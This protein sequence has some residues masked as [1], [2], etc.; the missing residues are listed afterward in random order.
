M[1]DKPI[2][3]P[4]D[5]DN[6]NPNK[7]QMHDRATW[8]YVVAMHKIMVQAGPYTFLR[9]AHYDQSAKTMPGATERRIR[10]Y[11]LLRAK[12]RAEAYF[13]NQNINAA[14]RSRSD[15]AAE[16]LCLTVDQERAR[17]LEVEASRVSDAESASGQ[18]LFIDNSDDVVD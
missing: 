12:I 2:P 16:S 5:P 7:A 9:G 14:R 6:L 1:F 8:T 3:L 11:W 17:T 4:K 10:A 18:S 13:E 15:E